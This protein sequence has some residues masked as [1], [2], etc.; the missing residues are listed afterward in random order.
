VTFLSFRLVFA[1]TVGLL[2]GAAYSAPQIPE[3]AERAEA[4]IDAD[5]LRAHL[6]FL[7]SDELQG[8]GTGHT[9]N[10]VAELYLAT[11]FERLGLAR[12]AEAAFLQPVELYST[13][14]GPATELVVT[15]QVE[16]AEVAT[17]YPPGSDF[18]PHPASASRTVSAPLVFAG[19]G[20]TAPD[21]RYD[22]YHGLDASGRIVIALDGEPQSDETAGRFLGRTPT[23]YAAIER[24]LEAAR[25]SGAV[26]LLLVRSRMREVRSV[27]P[28]NP[29]VRSRDFA[30]ASKIDE[31]TLAVGTISPSAANKLLA[32][33]APQDRDL[34][35]LRRRID[36]ALSS[37]GD[38]AVNSPASFAIP[39]RQARLVVDLARDR[40]VMHNVVAM[41][42]GSDR[43]LKEE[44]VVIG[45]HFDHDGIDDGGRVFNGADD[46]G[47]GTV[48]V[49]EAA[50]AFAEA[51]RAGARPARTV[52]FALWNGEE[53]G[54]LGS[55]FYA[56]HP[57]PR[58][59]TVVANVNLDMVGRDEDIPDPRDYRFMGLPKTSAAENRNAL[60]VL[61][62]SYSPEL[63]QII[64]DENAAVGL[65]IKQT[66]DASPSNLLRRSD[67]WS[68]LSRRIPSV[69]LTSGLHPDYHTPQDDVGRINFVKLEKVARL[70]FRVGWRLAADPKL[71]GYVEPGGAAA[72][73]SATR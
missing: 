25:A 70:A 73:T 47:S 55:R 59:G 45:A 35:A 58:D 8:R 52:V 62:Y 6:R 16:R 57:V 15:E 22:D 49:L 38:R 41:V 56:D 61:G 48:A 43:K 11:A 65:T 9:G 53:K 5:D 30:L 27:W 10:Q 31:E 72:P 14:L 37:A 18:Q 36:A 42:E 60:H 4:A 40:T 71:P 32:G 21:L 46:D 51:A 24:K 13:T 67:H 69:F 1:L 23:A 26:G 12:A 66:L 44:L 34:D 33:L 3:A 50:E 19:Y 7:A 29:S 20:I 17:R 64:R 28:E 39:A 54:L 63:A 68:F 2:A